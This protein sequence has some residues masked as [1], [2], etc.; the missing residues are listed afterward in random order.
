MRCKTYAY[1][2]SQYLECVMRV[3]SYEDCGDVAHLDR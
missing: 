2:G 3:Q 1:K